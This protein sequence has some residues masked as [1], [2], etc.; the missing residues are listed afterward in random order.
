MCCY[1]KRGAF[2]FLLIHGFVSFV[3]AQKQQLEAVDLGLSVNWANM[4][5]GAK[6]PEEYGNYFAWGEIEEK[7]YYYEYISSKHIDVNVEG[8]GTL[9]ASSVSSA[10]TKYSKMDRKTVLDNEDDCANRIMGSKWNVPTK[11]QMQEL[12]DNCEWT[13][14]IKN[15]TSGIL[16]KSKVNGNSIFLP[17]AGYKTGHRT[18]G[19][20]RQYCSTEAFYWTSS[21]NYDE[22]VD[23]KK[24][25]VLQAHA[26][27]MKSTSHTLMPF[28]RANGCVVRAVCKK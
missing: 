23:S 16:V 3:Y 26:L 19:T 11:E 1:M 5:V 21:L 27:Y 8:V 17:L 12:I 13:Y 18:K 14:I 2:I 15:G 28:H 10:V 24:S 9:G 22:S 7:R 20:I 6:S 4:N 25:N